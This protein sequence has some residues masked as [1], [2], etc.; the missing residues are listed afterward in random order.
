MLAAGESLPGA[1]P[2]NHHR[3]ITGVIEVVAV[4]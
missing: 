3:E 4:S 2:W 1:P